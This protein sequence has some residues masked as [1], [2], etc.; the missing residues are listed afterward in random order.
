MCPQGALITPPTKNEYDL[1]AFEKLE[2]GAEVA[3]EAGA[4]PD[5][6]DAFASQ[7]ASFEKLFE[8]GA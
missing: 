4:D 8:D 1:D 2:E 7:R 5:A 6:P 3:A